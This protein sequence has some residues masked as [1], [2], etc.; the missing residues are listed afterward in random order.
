MGW[1]RSVGSIVCTSAADDLWFSR[2]RAPPASSSSGASHATTCPSDEKCWCAGCSMHTVKLFH[3]LS[4]PTATH[5]GA[6]RDHRARGE[7]LDSTSTT[8]SESQSVAPL[9]CPIRSENRERGVGHEGTVPTSALSQRSSRGPS[10]SAAIV[11][12]RRERGLQER[13]ERL[14]LSLSC[15][16]SREAVVQGLVNLP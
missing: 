4:H 10:A 13:E 9:P 1:R 6:S 14:G 5:T 11:P 15:T 8:E 3:R 7:A 2:P 16:A 12:A